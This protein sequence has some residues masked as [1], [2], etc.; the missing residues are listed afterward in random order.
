[1][2]IDLGSLEYRYIKLTIKD[3]QNSNLPLKYNLNGLKSHGK[4]DIKLYKNLNI[5]QNDCLGA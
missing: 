4:V 5:F 3:S 1:M 2:K